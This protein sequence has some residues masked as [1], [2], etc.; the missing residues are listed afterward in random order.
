MLNAKNQSAVRPTSAFRIEPLAFPKMRRRQFIKTV[1]GVLVPASVH[2]SVPLPLGFWAPAGASGGGGPSVL[3]SDFPGLT[4]WYRS[5]DLSLND[6]DLVSTWVD[7]T[8]NHNDATAAGAARPTFKTNILDGK[9]ALR[10]A[11]GDTTTLTVPSFNCIGT[12]FAIILLLKTSAT[13]DWYHF[14]TWQSG[15]ISYDY[16][17]SNRVHLYDTS[18]G[19]DSDVLGTVTNTKLLS[20]YGGFADQKVRENKTA[21]GGWNSNSAMSF[22]KL[23]GSHWV[24]DLVEACIMNTSLNAADVDSLYDNYFKFHYPSLP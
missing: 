20:I 8:S 21:R 2:A 12:T 10:F 24:G 17:S 18:N 22:N 11:G 6:G 13:S 7:R 15:Y 4:H 14:L 9:P 3:P 23:I 16:Q 19:Y 5:M 1:G